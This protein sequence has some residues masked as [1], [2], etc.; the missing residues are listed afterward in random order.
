MNTRRDLKVQHYKY[1]IKTTSERCHSPLSTIDFFFK[2]SLFGVVWSLNYSRALYS[3]VGAHIRRSS[4]GIVLERRDGRNFTLVREEH[5]RPIE[6]RER[7]RFDTEPP[8]DIAFGIRGTGV[9]YGRRFMR[10]LDD[11]VRRN[12]AELGA[13]RERQGAM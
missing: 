11:K 6:R 7:R 8:E 12:E 4:G 3:D 9:G 2:V 13:R 10:N 5:H 1:N